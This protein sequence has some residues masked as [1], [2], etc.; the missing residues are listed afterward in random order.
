[1][2]LLSNIG[3]IIPSLIR[4]MNCHIM[5]DKGNLQYFLEALLRPVACT[6]GLTF[7]YLLWFQVLYETHGFLEKNRDFLHSDLLQLLAS[8]DCVLAQLFAASIGDGVQKMQSP[9]RRVNSAESQKQSVATKFKVC[10]T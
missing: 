5:E 7:L 4:L 3:N 6:I 1:M 2:D 9:T 10:A 8:C